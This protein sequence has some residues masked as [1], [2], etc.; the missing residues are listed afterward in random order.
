MADD[1]KQITYT[2]LVA[3]TDS[4]TIAI[5]QL[6]EL[7][8]VYSASLSKLKKDAV[9]LEKSVKGVSGATEDQRETI[10]TS[11]TEVDKL[12]KAQEALK[13]SRS[14]A[15]IE[16]KKLKQTQT[17]QNN[18]TKLEL[19]LQN[20]VKGS[21]NAL[22]AEYSLN[23]IRL[24]KM[25]AAQRETTASGKKLE[26]ETAAIY[27]E[28][29]RLQ[30][31]TGKHTL[32]VGDYAKANE[33]LVGQLSAMPNAAGKAAGGL[34][35][36]GAKAKAL[37]ANPIVLTISLIVAGLS[38]LFNLF[39]KTKTGSDLLAKGG[40]ALEG[41]MSALV[42]IV[43]VLV[44]GLIY[45]F[46]EPKKAMETFWEA[47]K[48]N[49]VNRLTGVIELVKALG[50]SFKALWERDLDGL[51]KASVDAG[52]ALIQMHTG[53]DTEQQKAFA[54][55]VVDTT[56]SII[57]Q[58]DAFAELTASQIKARAENRKLE[59]SMESLITKEGEYAAIAD[60][61]TRSFKER[62]DAA[63]RASKVTIQRASIEQKIARTNL[64]LINDELDLR[65]KNGEEV[66]E[67]LDSQLGAY[68]ALRAAEREY[69][70]SV[71]ENDK[72]TAELKQ[73]RLEKDLDIL[74]DG[75]DNQKSINERL[76]ND[77]SLTFKEREKL[78]NDTKK[79]FDDSFS[80]QVET[81]QKF[82]GV[83]I[84][85]NDLIQESDAVVLNQKIRS[86][87]L[88]EIIE[89][90][91]LEIIR[92]RRT[93]VQD[94][95][96]AEVDL[97]DAQKK[98]IDDTYKADV[99]LFN[100]EQELKN[101]EIDLLKT[102][103]A[104]KTKLRLQAEKDRLNKVISLN[105]TSGQQL[106]DLQIKLLQ[107]QIAKIDQMLSQGDPDKDIYSMAGLKLGDDEKQVISDS[108]QFAISAVNDFL[109]ANINAANVSV[110]ISDK[111]VS[112]AESTLQAEL[113]ARNSGYASNVSQA[114]KEVALAKKTQQQALANQEKA[115]REQAALQ[116]IQQAG[117]LLLASSKIWGQLGFPWAIP[118]LGVMWGSFAYS[119]VKAAQ[120][121]KQQYGDGGF[122]VLS[123][124][125]H[126]SG[127]D[128]YLG[129]SGGVDQFA[130]GGEGRAIFSRK[131]TRRY[132]GILPSIVDSL[133]KGVFEKKYMGAYD[134]SSFDLNIMGGS[135]SDLSKL[136][137]D[138]TDIRKQGERRYIVDGKGRTIEIYKNL[139]RVHAN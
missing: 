120:V 60:D 73:D 33:N 17:E 91:L 118:A 38:L 114:Q 65:V 56:N 53:L 14:N 86:L 26:S 138:V 31:A 102:T 48:K 134:S 4:I 69:S 40:A 71:H 42:G 117:N 132:S 7:M 10:K 2:D 59:K 108:T 27:E 128:I 58:A 95:K 135:S 113:T 62:E 129:N 67:L 133:N 93:G 39:K 77:D 103:E 5:A 96:E 47:L 136:E 44:N 34:Q 127:N 131:A 125:S 122:D 124:G 80:K 50:A 15:G 121:T 12:A 22:S 46:T 106:S 107:N 52:R 63:A 76:L 94:L 83:Q 81:V 32:S 43:D 126:A 97:G 35:D 72:R 66:G 68:K 110:Q 28:M 54:K 70:M 23:K 130:E 139:K 79:L 57:E 119:K 30:E 89:G 36:L 41:V 13:Q 109:Q 82:T 105:K 64:K 1:N 115:T 9:D 90:R 20:S 100:Q 87:G 92:D 21:Y 75:F 88:S 18:L 24:N 19:K 99:E 49:I 78:L 51:K 85:A 111:K 29:K 104:E 112:S 3:P 84:D 25:S 37:L 98:R 137:G 11:A 74:I 116:S 101:S 45:L 8:E 61:N 16:L 123:G 6:T 55:A